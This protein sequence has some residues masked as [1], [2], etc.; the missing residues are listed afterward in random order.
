MKSDQREIG[1]PGS[2]QRA[3]REINPVCAAQIRTR[4]SAFRALLEFV[5][6][7]MQQAGCKQGCQTKQSGD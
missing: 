2:D 4:K 3:R 1:E 7:G 6:P 5:R